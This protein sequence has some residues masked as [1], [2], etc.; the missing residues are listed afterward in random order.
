MLTRN[1]DGQLTLLVI[2]YAFLALVLVIVGVDVSAAFLARRELSSVADAAAIAAAQQ[3]DR[4]A[5]YAGADRACSPLPVDASAAGAA[6]EAAVADDLPEL[7][8]IFVRLDPPQTTA[9]GGAVSIRLSGDAHLPFGRVIGLLL[10]G[11]PTS[12][13]VAVTAHAESAVS[14][15]DGC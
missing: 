9:A 11:R 14:G 4:T 12:V 7:E 13:P 3:V 8:R 2:G 10:P 6:V 5:V 1:D 15:A